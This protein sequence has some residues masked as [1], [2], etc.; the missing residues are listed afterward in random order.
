MASDSDNDLRLLVGH[1]NLL[2]SLMIDLANAELE[3]ERLVNTSASG[4]DVSEETPTC[5]WAGTLVEKPK[6]ETSRV[7]PLCSLAAHDVS[8]ISYPPL[9]RFKY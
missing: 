6:Q 8:R 3:Q 9:S 4:A 7:T 5:Q 2:T 1:A